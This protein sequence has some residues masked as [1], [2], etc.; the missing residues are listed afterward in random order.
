MLDITKFPHDIQDKIYSMYFNK[1]AIIIQKYWRRKDIYLNLVHELIIYLVCYKSYIDQGINIDNQSNLRI[2]NYICNH[3][4]I[5]YKSSQSLYIWEEFIY[6]IQL[7]IRNNQLM[8]HST[9]IKNILFIISAFNSLK[10]TMKE[11]NIKKFC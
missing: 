4:S 5:N 6:Q 11:H 10:N 8:N 3:F 2:I 9:D 7:C 1:H